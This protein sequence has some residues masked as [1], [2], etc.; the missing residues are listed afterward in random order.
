[1]TPDKVSANA[2]IIV[3]DPRLGKMWRR[4]F[5]GNPLH[6]YSS[7]CELQAN[8]KSFGDHFT[9]CRVQLLG[10]DVYIA[11]MHTLLW[12]DTMG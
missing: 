9:E 3:S 2:L 11:V 7:V 12:I 6:A 1:M 4:D 8:V 10:I 5:S